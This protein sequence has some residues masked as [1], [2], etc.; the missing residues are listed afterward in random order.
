VTKTKVCKVCK[1]DFNP[2]R[3]MQ[4][5][6]GPRCAIQHSSLTNGKAREKAD[7]KAHRG[8]KEAIKSRADWAKEA[9]AAFNGFIRVRD[10]RQAC[11]SCGQSPYQGQRHASHYRSVGA[12]THL[13]FN[14]MNVHASCAQCNSMKSGNVVEYRISLVRKIGQGRVESLEHSN[15]PRTFEIGELKRIKRVFSRKAKHYRKLRAE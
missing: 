13:R 15:E 4:A 7:Q 10:A 6:C 5:V 14:A 1:A 8:R 9:Q 2:V 11:I 12:A 3:S